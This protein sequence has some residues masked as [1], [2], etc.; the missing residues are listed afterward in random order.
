MNSNQS[1]HGDTLL[2]AF[3]SAR[4]GLPNPSRGV[5]TCSREEAEAS[6]RSLFYCPRPRAARRAARRAPSSAFHPGVTRA[7][8]VILGLF[9][10]PAGNVTVA[11]GFAV[12]TDEPDTLPRHEFVTTTAEGTLEAQYAQSSD[13]FLAP[14][15]TLKSSQS[16]S[17]SASSF[18][19]A[20]KVTPVAQTP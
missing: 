19:H 18:R 9:G 16:S 12:G 7:N 20:S 10:T 14:R 5:S 17:E 11:S 1:F 3:C 6:P 2:T 15:R 4:P 13:Q 8:N